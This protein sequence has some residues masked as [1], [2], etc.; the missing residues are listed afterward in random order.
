M[1]TCRLMNAQQHGQRVQQ[2]RPPSSSMATYDELTSKPKALQESAHL[3]TRTAAAR[4]AAAGTAPLSLRASMSDACKKKW[5]SNSHRR[6]PLI[7]WRPYSS[8]RCVPSCVRSSAEYGMLHSLD[9]TWLNNREGG[10]EG[11][12]DKKNTQNQPKIA[13]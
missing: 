1:T 7:S 3:R 9:K 11:L 6:G 13:P 2:R 12:V 4:T 8:W 10:C 5:R